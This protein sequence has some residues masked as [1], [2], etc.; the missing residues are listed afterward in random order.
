MTKDV[1]VNFGKHY[2]PSET[3]VL[4]YSRIPSPCG[5][6][7]QYVVKRPFEILLAMGDGPFETVRAYVKVLG[8]IAENATRLV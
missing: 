8:G 7:R 6:S 2:A 3:S 5:T 4:V 1:P